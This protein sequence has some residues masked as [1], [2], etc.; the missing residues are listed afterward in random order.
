MARE[1]GVI[2]QMKICVLYK[3]IDAPW[4]GGNSFLRSLKKAWRRSGVDVTNKIEGD[5]DVI[6]F[7]S[8]HLGAGKWNK[9]L[10]Q[11]IMHN[12]TVSGCVHSLPKHLHLSRWK[13][14]TR[15][16]PFV[17]RLDGVFRLYGRSVTDISDKNQIKINSFMDWT[18]Y[19]SEFGRQSF[20]SEGVDITKSS[21]IWNG[22]DI[23]K[24]YPSNK[25]KPEKLLK[26][27]AVSWSDNLRKGAEQ[28]AQVSKLPHTKITFIGRWPSA[29]SSASVEIIPP[30]SHDVLPDILREHDAMLNMAQNEA[31]SNAILEGIACGLPIIYHPSG[32]TPEIIQGCGVSGLPDLPK[33][34]EE[35]KDRYPELRRNCIERQDA[36]SIYSVAEKYLAVFQKIKG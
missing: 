4:G 11:E 20:G 22:V 28:V 29:V 33:A 1:T 18:I 12:I 3:T 36:L 16:P 19:Q 32:G 21:V 14:A 30:V 23:E 7:N 13:K 6:L 2:G 5:E 24:F 31:C 10:T 15:R 34:L 35:L 27:V 25:K 9:R 17:H 26:L 8:A